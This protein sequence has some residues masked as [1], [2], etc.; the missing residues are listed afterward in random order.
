MSKWPM[1]GHFRYLSFK[2]F[3]MS[4]RTPQCKVFWALLSSFKH[5]RV[6]EDSKSPTLGVGVSSSHFTQSG[7]ATPSE[8]RKIDGIWKQAVEWDGAKVASTWKRDVG[9]HTLFQDLGPLHK[10]Q[11]CG[12]VDRQCDLEVVC[13]STQVVIKTNKMARHIGIVQC[14]Y[15]A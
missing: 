9:C 15:P 1:Q 12:G 13:N 11:G 5:S 10:L 6:P 2:T 3:P 8:R 14:G 7:V 4:P